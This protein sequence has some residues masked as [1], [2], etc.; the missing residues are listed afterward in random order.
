MKST[1]RSRWRPVIIRSRGSVNTR[2]RPSGILKTDGSSV[3]ALPEND[4]WGEAPHAR[5]GST[6][7]PHSR[8][9]VVTTLLRILFVDFGHLRGTLPTCSGAVP[10]KRLSKEKFKVSVRIVDESGH[11]FSSCDAGGIYGAVAENLGTV[12][13]G[14][15]LLYDSGGA[16]QKHRFFGRCFSL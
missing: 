15:R 3:C 2:Q 8:R 9:V 7:Q 13:C 16:D 10:L 11:R 12:L 5:A 1:P 4:P 14:S 6:S